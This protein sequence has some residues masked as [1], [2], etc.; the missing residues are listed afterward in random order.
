MQTTLEQN[1]W[2]KA[3]GKLVARAWSDD[4]FK[5]RLIDD[6]AAV[7]AEEGIEVPAGIEL[8]V[9]E[10]TDDVCHLVLPPSPAGEFVDEDLSPTAGLYCYSGGCGACGCGAC[11]CGCRR[12]GCFGDEA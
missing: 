1:T 8:K 11:G 2:Q 6:P 10:D 3:W 12:C 5:Q 4:D 7:L 9:V